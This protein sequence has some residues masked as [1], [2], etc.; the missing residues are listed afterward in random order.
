M[1]CQW[2]LIIPCF[3]CLRK[4]INHHPKRF[5]FPDTHTTEICPIKAKLPFICVSRQQIK[6]Q[7]YNLIIYVPTLSVRDIYKEI[8]G[9]ASRSLVGNII[10]HIRSSW[11]W[12]K[13]EPESRDVTTNYT[14]YVQTRTTKPRCWNNFCVQHL[15][16]HY[17][18][19]LTISQ[20][21]KR[22]ACARNQRYPGHPPKYPSSNNW[23]HPHPIQKC[24]TIGTTKSNNNWNKK[25]D[26]AK[27]PQ[28]K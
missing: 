16:I 10:K 12:S 28:R 5:T 23:Q 22:L 1:V 21:T 11:I 19:P 24:I 20:V 2:G 13:G 26:G 9:K 17:S 3:Y 6:V 18:F 27:L 7:I 25:G 8:D 4:G 14:Y 15:V